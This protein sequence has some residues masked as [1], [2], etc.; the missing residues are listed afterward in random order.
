[1]SSE[2][3]EIRMPDLGEID[4]AILVAWL[5][6]T[7]AQVSEGDDLLEIETD[8]ATFVI[9]APVDGTLHEI[10]VQPMSPID[11]DSVLGTLAT[12]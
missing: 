8:K 2:R 11:E 9:P 10:L 3:L 6:E 4:R 7:G 5:V 1:M 12:A